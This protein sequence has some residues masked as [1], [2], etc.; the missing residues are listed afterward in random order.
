MLY[1]EAVPGRLAVIGGDAG[2]EFAQLFHRLESKATILDRLSRT[3]YWEDE[4][5]SAELDK[6]LC[7]EGSRS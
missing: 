7:N 4:D 2:M 3:T 1:V 6:I 5:V